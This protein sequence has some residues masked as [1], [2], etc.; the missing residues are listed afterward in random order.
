MSND[1]SL[2]FIHGLASSGQGYKG[3]MLRRLFPGILTPDFTDSLEERLA[4]LA[5]ILSGKSNWVII[6][7]SFG[8]LM[9]ALF[10]C[11][12]PQQVKKLI[13]L[14]PALIFPDFAANP[15]DPISVPTVIYHGRHDS[16]VPVEPVR[17]LAEQVF[18]NLTFHLVDDDHRLH[19]TVQAVDWPALVG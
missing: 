16:V 10:T 1:N 12:Q 8:G 2:I 17:T 15:P 18:L 6:G 13:L 19:Q 3:T 7:S 11:Q 5:P 9:G 4:Q 14:A